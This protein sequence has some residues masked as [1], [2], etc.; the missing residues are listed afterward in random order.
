MLSKIIII[1][2]FIVYYTAMHMVTIGS[3][4]YRL[5]LE[6]LMIAMASAAMAK[7]IHLYIVPVMN[8]KQPVT[9]ERV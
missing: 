3:L 2:I 7:V 9:N 5:P 4:R 1:L 6:P 8:K